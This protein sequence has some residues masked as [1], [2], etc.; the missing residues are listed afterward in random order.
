MFTGAFGGLWV[1]HGASA[2]AQTLMRNVLLQVT[3]VFFLGSLQSYVCIII[4][5]Y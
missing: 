1:L 4:A 2:F 3:G 5:I